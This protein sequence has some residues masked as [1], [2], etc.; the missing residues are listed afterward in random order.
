MNPEKWNNLSLGALVNFVALNKDIRNIEKLVIDTRADYRFWQI[1]LEERSKNTK[2][3]PPGLAMAGLDISSTHLGT[4]AVLARLKLKH[5]DKMCEDYPD[6][7]MNL[8]KHL[9]KSLSAS[10]RKIDRE[11]AALIGICLPYI[12]FLIIETLCKKDGN[13]VAFDEYYYLISRVVKYLRGS[14]LI[15]PGRPEKG[16][17][18]PGTPQQL[19]ERSESLPWPAYDSW[20]S[21]ALNLI[22]MAG[23]ISSFERNAVDSSQ[24]NQLLKL[25][26]HVLVIAQ[27]GWL[28]LERLITKLKKISIPN[29]E[30]SRTLIQLEKHSIKA[31]YTLAVTEKFNMN[32]IRAAQYAWATLKKNEL[33]KAKNQQPLTE[34]EKATLQHFIDKIGIGQETIEAV[35]TN[36]PNLYGLLLRLNYPELESFFL[37]LEKKGKHWD[38]FDSGLLN[39]I[40]LNYQDD[41]GY[42]QMAFRAAIRA[43]NLR[44]IRNILR[45]SFNKN[46]WG[47][48]KNSFERDAGVPFR[49]KSETIRKKL[50]SA[51]TIYELLFWADVVASIAQKLVHV[52]GE[53]HYQY[54]ESVRSLWKRMPPEE[55]SL[56]SNKHILFLHHILSGFTLHALGQH[57]MGKSAGWILYQTASSEEFVTFVDEYAKQI[58]YGSTK[59]IPFQSHYFENNQIN[60]QPDEILVSMVRCNHYEMSLLAIGPDQTIFSDTVITESQQHIETDEVITFTWRDIFTNAHKS[61]NSQLRNG[62]IPEPRPNLIQLFIVIFQ[63]ACRANPNF[64]RLFIHATPEFRQIPWQYVFHTNSELCSL[65]KEY[66]FGKSRKGCFDGHHDFSIWQIPGLLTLNIKESIRE[67]IEES[68][69]KERYSRITDQS[70]SLCIK[71]NSILETELAI[72]ARTPISQLSII[73]HGQINSDEHCTDLIFEGKPWELSRNDLGYQ[74]TILHTCG[75]SYAVRNSN[76]DYGGVLGLLFGHGTR[77]VL[78]SSVVIP[79]AV[80]KIQSSIPVVIEKKL[81]QLSNL[82]ADNLETLYIEA[83]RKEPLCALYSLFGWEHGPVLIT[84]EQTD[85]I[86]TTKSSRPLSVMDYIM[87]RIKNWVSFV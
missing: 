18:I 87:T 12:H 35:S 42:L 54:R 66:F 6:G 64:S 39:D 78:A 23:V 55:R 14:N 77:F 19:I 29:D 4:K 36:T 11:F 83:V 72:L 74:L 57:A 62:K 10:T 81:A 37:L 86:I 73:A 41:P 28:T 50:C 58:R 59:G 38:G 31:L 32:N 75:A 20:M 34:S 46:L 45:A 49:E 52:L 22:N 7:A 51:L 70:D 9:G 68:L 21:V 56:L 3:I 65:R 80:D 60:L 27:C 82:D 43:G 26:E 5:I 2:G 1:W 8:Y 17:G 76:S 33:Y 13:F 25:V 79:I 69:V 63:L 48:D 85:P 84:G 47:N 16:L 15:A 24:H 67:S 40:I 30:L 61:F 71:L 53:N 44:W